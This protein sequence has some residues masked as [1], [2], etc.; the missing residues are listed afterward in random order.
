M[1]HTLRNFCIIAHIDHGKSTLADRLL[2]MTGTVPQRLMHAQVLDSMELERERGITIRSKTIRMMYDSGGVRYTLNLIDTPGHVDFTY[3]VMRV[4]NAC[5][6]ALLVVDASQGV[7]AQTLANTHLARASGLHIIP[8]LNKVDLPG[9]SPDAVALQIRESLG[10]EREPL[11]ISA[12]TGMG[13]GEVLEAIVREIPPPRVH[14]K[15]FFSALVFDAYYDAYRGV[16]MYVRVLSGTMKRG[17]S[18]RFGSGGTVY[19]AED[20]GHIRL[21]LESAAELGPGDVGYLVAGV[22]DI[23]QIRIGDVI[24]DA[25]TDRSTWP[26]VQAVEVK[27]YVFAGIYPLSPKDYE[28]LQLSLIH[29]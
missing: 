15:P 4:M 8:L 10:I 21:S 29:I 2:E 28:A 24:G 26:T 14:P 25:C 23:H 22:K 17:M 16:V 19:R 5:D 9:A 3:E 6:G 20:I 7:E 27:P 11:R 13:V 1:T 12:K 18:F